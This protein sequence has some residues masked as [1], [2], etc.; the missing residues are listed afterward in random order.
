MHMQQEY[1]YRKKL[2]SRGVVGVCT[3]VAIVV[4]MLPQQVTAAT[5]SDTVT[6]SLAVGSTISITSP[7]D[8]T[9]NPITGTGQS[10]ID[11]N[12]YRTWNVKTNNATGYALSWQASTAAM[13]SG[14]DTIAAYTPA[15]ANTPEAWSVAS[16][17]SEW[18]A[19]LGSAST[20]ADTA[21]WGAQDTYSG[22]WLNIAT[23][24]R[25]LVTR[26]TETLAAGDDEI[27]YF[28]AEIGSTKAQPSGTYTVNVTMTATTNP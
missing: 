10:T 17:D 12:N 23:S 22:K 26:N 16:T 5:A 15:V 9:M 7:T 4:S 13:T 6:A 21:T 1:T 25:T 2:S 11:S 3:L 19:H 18:G 8:I 28:G 24:S 20:T 27:V 14:S